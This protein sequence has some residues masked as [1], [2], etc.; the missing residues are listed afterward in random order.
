MRKVARYLGLIFLSI[1]TACKSQVKQHFSESHQIDFNEVLWYAQ[2]ASLAYSDEKTIKKA[3]PNAT[4]VVELKDAV[5][6]FLEIDSAN[7]RQIISVRGTS[8]LKNAKED[9]Q[10]I[11]IKDKLLNNYIHRGFDEASIQVYNDVKPFLNKDYTTV[12]TGHSLGAAISTLLMARL[13]LDGFKIGK[14]INFGQPK[15][16]NKEGAVKYS[17]LSLLR[18]VDNKDLVPLCPPATILNSL[19][20][21]YHHFGRELILF[22]DNY[23]SFLEESDAE[24]NITSEFWLSFG[25]KSLEDHY[26]ENY[27]KNIKNKIESGGIET[28]YK[29]R[30][31][32]EK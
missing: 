8:N 18:V 10:H 15:L 23:Y 13:E 12:C 3:L 21:T 4:R 14:S 22:K 28:E 2:R 17:H 20:G 30:K 1:L 27:I 32:H 31:R 29:S 19:H 24:N 9:A 26:M 7:N 11:P 5:Q 16:T 6:Y 25:E